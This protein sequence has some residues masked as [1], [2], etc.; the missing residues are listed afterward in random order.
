MDRNTLRGRHV[1]VTALLGAWSGVAALGGGWI[2]SRTA[3]AVEREQAQEVRRTEARTKRAAVY[4][5]FLSAVDAAIVP[6]FRAA[7]Q[8]AGHRCK[9]QQLEGTIGLQSERVVDALS[10]VAFYGSSDA[11]FASV[12]LVDSFPILLLNKREVAEAPTRF[13]G[14]LEDAYQ[15]FVR[16]M[17]KEVSAEPRSTCSQLLLPVPST[18]IPTKPGDFFRKRVGGGT[19]TIYE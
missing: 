1:L 2:G 13:N 8:C 15:A 7:E 16:I 9:P 18:L 4:N 11:N 10:E 5:T 6:S 17:C 12:G 14:Q 3:L 19:I